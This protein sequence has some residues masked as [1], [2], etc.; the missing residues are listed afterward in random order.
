[1]DS[2]EYSRKLL[3]TVSNPPARDP[4]VTIDRQISHNAAHCMTSVICNRLV[5]T[6]VNPEPKGGTTYVWDQGIINIRNAVKP[7][8]W[9]NLRLTVANNFHADA[10][11]IPAAYFLACWQPTD[12]RLHVWTIPEPVMFD[13][14]ERHPVRA[15]KEKRTIQ[16]HL[17]R[18][19]QATKAS[20]IRSTKRW[21]IFSYP[22]IRQRP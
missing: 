8:L 1:M 7:F 22:A 18:T 14:L 13:A 3:T 15:M 16:R 6:G 9:T 17:T 21:L 4:T 10:A 11:A 2:A 12:D 5:S 19:Y 20:P